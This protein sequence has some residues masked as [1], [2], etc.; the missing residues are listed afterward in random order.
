MGLASDRIQAVL[1]AGD[2]GASR[3]VQGHS[4][5]FVDLW[6]RPM[7]VHVLEA[8]LHTP[9]VSEVFV[10]GDSVRFTR[11]IHTYGILQLAENRGCPVHLIPQR[12]TLYQNVWHAFLRT[13]PMGNPDPDHAILVVPAD[14]PLVVPEEISDF[15]RHARAGEADYVAGISPAVALLP[16]A[17]R[18]GNPGIAMACFNLAEGRFRQN[19]LHFVRPLRLVNRHY[20]QDLYEN[21]YQKRVGNMLRLAGRILW[22]EYRHLWVFF[23]YLCLHLA[24][25][26]DRRGHRALADRVRA[27]IPLRTVERGIGELLGTCFRMVITGF[28]GA[29]VDIDNSADLQAAEKMGPCW[30]AAQARIARVA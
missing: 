19:N 8:L 16:F 11:L 23:A 28:G 10:V 26:L 12:D 29:A 15:L 9:E 22:R 13:C 4:K 27:K 21:R 7:V 6:G 2:R 5:A 24:A 30:K 3:A 18:D 20:I 25:V 1:L 14:I 17:P